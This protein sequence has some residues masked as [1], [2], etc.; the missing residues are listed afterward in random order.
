M[1]SLFQPRAR[2]LGFFPSAMTRCVALVFPLALVLAAGSAR[3]MII[4]PDN[5]SGTVTLPPG[6]Y[7]GAMAIID[8]LAP[9]TTIQI[10]ARLS[11]V[12]SSEGPGGSLGG[13]LQNWGSALLELDMVGTGSL[14]GFMRSIVVPGLNVE[15]HSGPRA[16]GTS[17]QD[18]GTLVDILLG[19]LPPGDPDF[20]LLRITAGNAFGLPS[21]GHTTLTAAGGGNWQVDS[22]FDISY[23]IDFVGAPGGP[24]SGMSGSTTGTERFTVT[25]E[26]SSILLLGIGLA[27]LLVRRARRC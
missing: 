1:R 24:I 10:D 2:I 3:A 25:P 5:G 12:A 8:G 16:A 23:R 13:E 20:D 18:F 22:F 9:G 4:A 17:P 6:S 21:P 27:G 15:T 11:P 7:V 26:P 19:Q 14:A